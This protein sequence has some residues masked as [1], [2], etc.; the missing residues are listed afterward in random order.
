MLPNAKNQAETREPVSTPEVNGIY[1]ATNPAWAVF[2]AGL[3]TQI[4][5]MEERFRSYWTMRA[6]RHSVGR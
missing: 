3:D 1:N 4:T 2:S 6:V 5:A